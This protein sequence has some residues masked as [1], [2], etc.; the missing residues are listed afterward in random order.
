MPDRET[1]SEIEDSATLWAARSERGLATDECAELDAWLA[2]DSRHLGAFVR[3]QAAWIHAERA[4]ALGAMPASA[5]PAE[6]AKL[7]AAPLAA[8]IGEVHIETEDETASR[9]PLHA[10]RRSLLV[11]GGALAASL[12]AV[13]LFALDRTRTLESG[14]GEIRRITLAG[15][16]IL[17]LDTD[18]RI[19]LAIGSE[20]R[21]LELVRGQLFLE[22]PDWM[23]LPITVHAGDLAFEMSRAAFALR[24][25]ADEPLAALVARGVLMA[26]QSGGIFG[27]RR[28]LLLEK[29][30]GLTHKAGT[31]LD[32]GS[33]RRVGT[34][35]RDRL[36]AWRDGMLSFAGETLAEA[37]RAFDRYNAVRIVV[38]DPGLSRQRVTGLFKATDPG[39]FAEA[40]A[41]SFGGVVERA[42]GEIRLSARKGPLA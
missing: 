33:V 9:S 28:T 8:A 36:L 1:A 40:T 10:N 18:S 7:P 41:A 26:S 20:D 42:G 17:T 35:E 12:A 15:G 31:P 19:D 30:H 3:A 5:E 14:V 32:G 11:G 27:D 2:K 37:V 39:G 24:R 4:A 22:L 23:D 16:S 21:R 29:D 38:A 25:D 13:G 6:T 34:A